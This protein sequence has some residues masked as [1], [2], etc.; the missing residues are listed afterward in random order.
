M[1]DFSSAQN[2]AGQDFRV[3]DKNSEKAF[4]GEAKPGWVCLISNLDAVH[5]HVFSFQEFNQVFKWSG[6]YSLQGIGSL[7]HRSQILS[8]NRSSSSRV[9]QVPRA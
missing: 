7:L 6:L 5:L 3:S 1:G 2:L 4:N 9:T 8:A